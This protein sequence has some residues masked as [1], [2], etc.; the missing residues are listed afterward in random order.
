M[1]IFTKNKQTKV[2]SNTFDL[3]HDRKLSGKMGNLI[4]VCVMDCVPGDK[5]SV[6]PS[7]MTRFAPLIAPVMHQVSVYVH[8][9]FVPNRI[10]FD[11]WEEFITGGREGLDNTAWPHIPFNPNN[12]PAGSLEDYLGLP[13]DVDGLGNPDDINIS[14][15]PHAAYNRIYNEYYR[16]QNVIP[17]VVDQL[18]IGSQSSPGS[19][20]VLHK[21]AWQHDYFTSALP[22]TQRGQEAL[23]PLGTEAPVQAYNDHAD[24]KTNMQTLRWVNDP[25]ATPLDG[26]DL[27]SGAKGPDKGPPFAVVGSPVN[28]DDNYYLDLEDSHFA[29][30]SQATAASII[31]LRRA[32]RLQ[33]FLE[34]N[35]RG[36]ARY[37][38]NIY[39]HFGVQSSDKRL[40]RPEFLGGISTPV[41]ISEVLQ[42]SSTDVTTP[43][44]NMSGHG[45]SVGGGEWLSHYCEEHG[46]LMGIMS[47]MPKS[48]YQQGIPRHFRRQDKFDYY[49]PEF[50][51][52]GEQAIEQLEIF[53]RAN[54][55]DSEST[56]GYTPR[57]SEYKFMN[58]SVHG[59]FRDSLA[60]WH[61]GRKFAT[62]PQ[63]NQDFIEMDS[64]EVDRIFAVQ[65]GDNMWCHVFN[66][67]KA[68]RKMPYFGDP[69][70]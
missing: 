57:Y 52:I 29:D 65:T 12:N 56:F 53:P 23:L 54:L 7:V 31:D 15:F 20:K 47:I 70:M 33:E 61:M 51:H 44:G 62:F 34:K 16:D 2:G 30:L 66:E 19:F 48:A 13:T 5:I 11:E 39:M 55:E 63:L 40:Q 46:Y 49:W 32:F 35:A 68:Q 3:S 1:S 59:D 14:A 38:E 26:E 50:A 69:K 64:D 17:P 45:V 42:T 36:G 10:L 24:H 28:P 58:S 18:Q 41:K 6:K 60:H 21:R 43:Q 22:W 25:D 37:I 4:P 27:F 8:Y 67:I 9:F